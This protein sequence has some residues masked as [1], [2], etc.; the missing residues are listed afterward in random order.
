M[1][2]TAMR[3][4]TDRLRVAAGA[5]ML[6]VVLYGLLAA[7]GLV[8]DHDSLMPVRAQQESRR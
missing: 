2:N 1:R 6:A 4:R 7:A 8:S 3:M 5:V